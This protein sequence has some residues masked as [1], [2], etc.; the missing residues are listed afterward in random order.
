M[1]SIQMFSTSTCPKCERLHAFFEENGIEI[2]VRDIDVDADA[3]TAALMFKI[4]S[5]PAL[6]AGEKVL[7]QK[8]IFSGDEINESAVLSFVK[9]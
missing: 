2:E 6:V 9:A 5:A 4:L 1:N 3:R 7:K 8:D